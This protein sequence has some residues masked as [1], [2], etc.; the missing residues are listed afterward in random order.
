MEQKKKRLNGRPH[1][2]QKFLVSEKQIDRQG[3]AELNSHGQFQG[4]GIPVFVSAGLRN[5]HKS[6][7]RAVMVKHGVQLDAAFPLPE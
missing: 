5:G 2:T 6:R 3:C 7:D 4:A 1:S